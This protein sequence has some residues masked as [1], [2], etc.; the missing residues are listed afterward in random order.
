MAGIFISDF[1]I[2]DNIKT[3][4][5]NGSKKDLTLLIRECRD[6]NTV[7]V[8]TPEIEHVRRDEWTVLLK[9]ELPNGVN[10]SY[11]RVV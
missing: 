9:I 5:A 3:Y 4:R 11:G 8:E 7:F 10:S 2:S 6:I 1:G